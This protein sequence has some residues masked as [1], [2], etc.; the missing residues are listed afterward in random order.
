MKKFFTFKLF[1]NKKGLTLIEAM[2]AIVI[3]VFPIFATLSTITFL[4]KQTNNRNLELLSENLSNF[5]LEDL[6]GRN[7]Y[8]YKCPPEDQKCLELQNVNIYN[9]LQFLYECLPQDKGGLSDPYGSIG[10]R[11]MKYSC[12][13]DNVN[14]TS[15]YD[16][17]N[18]SYVYPYITFPSVEARKFYNTFKVEIYITRYVNA[19]VDEPIDIGDPYKYIYKIDIVLL[20]EDPKSSYTNLKGTVQGW[21]RFTVASTEVTYHYP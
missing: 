16:E 13:N 9:N 17:N 4:Y 5:I 7:F 6:R 2:L 20:K 18:P 12:I 14:D 21:K 8:Y 3:F 19:D 11:I 1:K 10:E 15:I